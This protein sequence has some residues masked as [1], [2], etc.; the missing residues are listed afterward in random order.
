MTLQFVR[1][2][3]GPKS[4]TENAVQNL[5]THLPAEATGLYLAGLDAVGRDAHAGVLILVAL[6]S[7]GV[8]LLVR[9]LA[10]ASRANIITSVIAF[11]IWVYA[12]GYGP[13]QAFGLPPVRGFGA[14]LIIAYSTI[15][16][17]LS[18]RGII[19]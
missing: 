7:M 3:Q 12:L 1:I 16:T 15:V 6:V 19:R 8:L 14:F 17:I 4:P 11:V 10:K 18:S 13:F 5:L 9:Y 2:Q